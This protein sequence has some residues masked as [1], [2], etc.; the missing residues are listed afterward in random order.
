MMSFPNMSCWFPR[1]RSPLRT[2]QM[3]SAF[4]VISA[5]QPS[6]PNSAVKLESS[7]IDLYMHRRRN[8]IPFFPVVQQPYLDQLT[9]TSLYQLTTD[10]LEQLT[11]TSLDQLTIACPNAIDKRLKP[12]RR[13]L[14]QKRK[15]SHN[16]SA[17]ARAATHGQQ[18]SNRG[19]SRG[20][21]KG[22]SKG[23]SSSSSSSSSSRGRGSSSSSNSGAA[24]ATSAS[25][26]MH[27]I[28]VDHDIK[29][30]Q[31]LQ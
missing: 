22:S 6:T 24:D 7:A 14:R 19:S 28:K 13:S 1:R 8:P 27:Y 16:S 3:E 29:E 17:I 26:L 20:S 4:H 25:R 21:S 30:V 18:S 2:G 5:S 12:C 23:S 31:Q 10:Y 11:T 9:T 15:C